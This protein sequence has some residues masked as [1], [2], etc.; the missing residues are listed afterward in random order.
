VEV[1][2]DEAEGTRVVV[3]GAGAAG[4]ACDGLRDT[5]RIECL[6]RKD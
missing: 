2:A 5:L 4:G 1:D 6:C 3:G